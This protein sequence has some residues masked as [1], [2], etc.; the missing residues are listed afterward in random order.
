MEAGALDLHLPA[1]HMALEDEQD[2]ISYCPSPTLIDAERCCY[3]IMSPTDPGLPEAYPCLMFLAFPHSSSV[4]PF[5]EINNYLF[6]N[7]CKMDQV[8]TQVTK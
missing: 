1:K 5:E 7:E 8:C 6:S 2:T 4:T 3:T